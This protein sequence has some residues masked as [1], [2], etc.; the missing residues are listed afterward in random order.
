[1]KKFILILVIL[2]CSGNLSFSQDGDVQNN[3]YDNQESVEFSDSVK[4]LRILHWNDVHA[5]NM[6]YEVSKKDEETGEKTYYYLGGISNLLGYINMLKDNNT[7]LFDGG[8]SYQGSPIST[9]TRGFSQIE[10]LN[11]LEPDAFV[12]GNHEFDYGQ[13]ALDSALMMAEFDY[14]SAN[15]FFNP[16]NKTFGKPFIIEDVNGIKVGVI[17]ITALDLETLILPKN[18]S[19]RLQL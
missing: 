16:R 17:G 1:M 15:V 5:R 7:L 9:V 10:V 11:M 3:P 18:I 8:D 19:R 13:Y 12:I 2:L 6:P 4:T 14:L